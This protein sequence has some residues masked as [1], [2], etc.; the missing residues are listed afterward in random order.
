MNLTVEQSQSLEPSSA[1]AWVRVWQ[2]LRGPRFI[3]LPIRAIALFIGLIA[4]LPTAHESSDTSYAALRILAGLLIIMA[5]Y[6]PATIAGSGLVLYCVHALAFPALLN[7]YQ[8][9]GEVSIAIL[10]SYLRWWQYIGF[11]VLLFLAP[12]AM[13]AITGR[14]LVTGDLMTLLFGWI[15][16]SVMAFAAAIFE[17]RIQREITRRENAARENQQALEQIRIKFALDTHDTV[18]HGL[19][20][21]AAILRMIGL[22]NQKSGTSDPRLLELGLVNAHTQQQLRL[23]LGRLTSTGEM[24]NQT[25]DLGLDLQRA[26]ELIRTATEAGGFK[27]DFDLGPV[28]KVVSGETLDSALFVLK[29]LATNIVKHSS[30]KEHCTITVRYEPTA[31]TLEF[32]SA[33]PTSHTKTTLPRSLSS[34]VGRSGGS[35]EVSN[36]DGLYALRI[37]L[38]IAD[39]KEQN[40]S[41]E[42]YTS[43][44]KTG[45]LEA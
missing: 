16:G 41:S 26:A 32:S 9:V 12:R 28:P 19:A 45:S 34:R 2:K 13:A 4:M 35:S 33:N 10:L 24:T 30:E 40:T 36:Q 44:E 22:D 11:S 38:P 8:T 20:A 23:L 1:P 42:G 25:T 31:K 15:L 17:A 14:D 39:E 37:V 18:S 43:E 27:I 6:A 29:E 5:P 7:P 3:D 21:E